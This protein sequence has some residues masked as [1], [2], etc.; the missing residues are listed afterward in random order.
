MELIHSIFHKSPEIALFLSLAVGYFIG[1]IKFGK[2]Q[3][4][5]VGGSLLAAVVISQAGVSIDNGVKAVMFAV[6]IYA[7]G[8]DSGPGFFNSL[9]R[10][11]LREIAMALFLAVSALITVII[12]AKIFHLN[13]GLA[14]GLA[15]GA[16]TQSAIIGTA[17]DAIARLGLPAEEV[18]SLQSDVAI[19]Y[20]VTYVF[21]SL[22]AIIV[23]VNILPKF[24]GRDLRSAALDAEAKL[25][26]GTPSRA[27][28]Q[29]AALPEL[30]GRAFKVGAGAG[31]KVSEI[32]MAA[33]D[34]VSIEK[35]RRVGKEIEP[36]PNVVL[37]ADDVVLVVGRREG[38]VPIAPKIGTEISDVTDVSAV[39]Q[40]RQAVF[41]A[42]GL[43]HT[44]IQ[45]VRETVDRDLRHGVFLESITRVGQP[46]P[47]LPETKLEHGDV[48]TYFGS[49]KDTK[50]AVEATGYELP[51]SIKTDFIYMGVGMVVGLLIGLIVINVGGV[52][53][54]L[55]SGGGCLLAGLV[56]GWMRGKHP[57]YGVMPPA[58]SRLLQDFGLAAFVSVVG[59]N[60]GLQAVTTIKELGL[61]IFL[62][63]VFVTLFPL[64]LT[65]V[66]GRYVLR[67]DNAAILA[68]ALAGSRSANP[69]F[70]GVLDKAESAVPTVPFAI[71]YAI[72]NVL[73]TL[74]GPLV[75]GLV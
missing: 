2:F 26:G 46:V 58:A 14:A 38:M 10:K 62:L 12:C 27:P 43:N 47:I 52:P 21:G 50:R 45:K 51:Y 44:T 18:K 30:V 33:Q 59:L 61:T 53:L 68:G 11:T 32:E 48:L 64:L 20:A 4:G 66:F 41:T 35:I 63:G 72:A 16:L 42:K 5:G 55:G 71:T 28:G 1:Q 31:R 22:G 70:G 65:M 9:N 29:L 19:A 75:V 8:Y 54:T 25:A 69:A 56:F 60:S 7:V 57:M 36:G 37:A 23:C 15:G 74:L 17:G 13:K 40:T 73:L 3:L 6:F 39:M 67:Y 49:A 34:F 24:M